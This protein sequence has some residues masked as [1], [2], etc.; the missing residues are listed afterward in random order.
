MSLNERFYPEYGAGGF[1]RVDGTIQFYSRVN[2]LLLP[3]MVVMDLGA[4]RGHHADA[5][6]AAY[7]RQLCTLKGKVR[8][9]IGVD[10][11]EA[12]RENPLIDEAIVYD[13]KAMPLPDGSIDLILSDAVFEHIDDPALF[14]GEIDRVLKP[15][16]WVCARTPHL[17]SALV[18]AAS[19]IPNSQHKKALKSIQPDRKAED[20]FP[21]RYRLNTTG[22]L[23]RHFPK[24]KWRHY[25][26]T[27][28]PE[29]SY[30][31]ENPLIYRLFMVY[32]YVK[33]PVLGGESLNVFLR[34]R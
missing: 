10:V 33:K 28:S 21:T 24:A 31:F 11:D 17:Y 3:D 15:G 32:H 16:G 19:I 2:A 26:Y 9:V 1:T 25:S 6:E 30:H 12:V 18:A 20:V 27:W 7:T 29:P 13:G 4:G 34:K 5:S 22:A 23:K 14:A 8:R